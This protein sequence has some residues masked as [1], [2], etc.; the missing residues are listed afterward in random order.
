MRR[1]ID[2]LLTASALLAL[3]G[4]G[5]R[6]RTEDKL[7]KETEGLKFSVSV[8]EAGATMG[9]K[10]FS[11]EAISSLW[12]LV[13]DDQGFFV[14]CKQAV[15]LNPTSFSTD[16][17]TEYEF[18]VNLQA[19]L[20]KRTLHL[21]AN[22]NFA[23]NPV[24][25][26]TEYSV[27]RDLTVSDG[28]DAYWQRV[29][30]NDGIRSQEELEEM[31]KKGTLTEYYN[32]SGLKKIPLVRNF[33]KVHLKNEA[34][35][36][37][38]DG[39][40]LWNVPDR[41][42]V[43]PCVPSINSFAVYAVAG[44][45]ASLPN[46]PW[47][48]R[49]YDE[50]KSSYDGTASHGFNGYLPQDA[51][52]VNTDASKLTFDGSDKY[53]YERPYSDDVSNTAIIINGRYNGGTPTYYKID[54]VQEA[55][56]GLVTYYNIIRNFIYTA[57]IISC[58][59]D[60]YATAAEA[61]AAPASNNFVASVV[62]K[63]II[64]ISDGTSRLN[65]SYTDTT[66]VNTDPFKFRYQYIPDISS[67]T[68]IDNSKIS[69]Y[70]KATGAAVAPGGSVIKSWTSADDAK[71]WHVIT[72]TP[73]NPGDEEKTQTIIFYEPKTSGTNVKI[74]RTVTYHLR[75]PY[76]MSLECDPST[77]TS[78]IGRQMTL[79]IK[80]P[81]GLAS[82]LFP[83][84]F[85]ME[86]AANSLTPDVSKSADTYK[87]GYMST[88]YGTSITGSGKQS[89]GFTKTLTYSEYQALASTDDHAHK[90]LPCAFKTTKSSSATTIWVQNKYFSF[91]DG[92]STVTFSN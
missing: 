78:G 85:K 55:D 16:M 23:S 21:V 52:I 62:T 32:T 83:L 28:Q 69:T 87:S 51:Q 54:F 29:V 37:T 35:N 4:C 13:F 9:T 72:I 81:T 2:I 38:L 40:A 70:D 26:G 50:L 82:H 6:L 48:S 1:L 33:A 91:G 53:L 11:S 27:I 19:S 24:S 45:T 64:N 10:S 17:N 39:Y 8:P 30:L 36:F 41:G 77:V 88:W 73:Q 31:E 84:E 75:K 34:S 60:G 59:A 56:A 49:S 66:V 18:T 44:S 92:V 67:P 47:V 46:N 74:A 86:S 20:T 71:G 65:I 57:T 15:P 22:Y 12:V 63:D 5:D 58:S 7:T 89:F 76:T 3:A 42:C 80:I 61:A 25:Y 90:I 43:A 14:E 79:N 68:V